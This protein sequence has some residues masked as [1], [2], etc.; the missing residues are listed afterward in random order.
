MNDEQRGRSTVL[1]FLV[2]CVLVS[3]Q[4]RS[5]FLPAVLNANMSYHQMCMAFFA[6][7]VVHDLYASPAWLIPWCKSG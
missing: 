3:E 2:I 1:K 4:S 6:E 5:L 7:Y